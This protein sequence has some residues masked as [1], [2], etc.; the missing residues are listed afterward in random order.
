MRAILTGCL[1][2]LASS[3]QA[4]DLQGHRGARGLAPENTL[5]AFEKALK[6]GVTTLELDLAVTKDDVLVVSHDPRLNPDITRGPD[7]Q[8]LREP[9]PSIRSLDLAELRKFDVGRVQPGT[10]Y[11]AR[12][13][14]QAAQDGVRIPT[15]TEVFDLAQRL[16]ADQVR[17]NIEPKISPDR[18][19]APPELFAALVA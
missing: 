7:G 17:F 9:G 19:T 2:L 10:A 12:L 11:A 13:R 6:I 15:L 3:A 14:G 18:E 1:M 5:P 8:W 16:G 4:F